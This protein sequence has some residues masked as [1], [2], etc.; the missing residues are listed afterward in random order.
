MTAKWGARI[1]IDVRAVFG[2]CLDSVY[3]VYV[4]KIVLFAS[5]IAYAQSQSKVRCPIEGLEVIV[6]D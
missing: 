6:R 5:T 2:Q 3:A 4:Q 1:V